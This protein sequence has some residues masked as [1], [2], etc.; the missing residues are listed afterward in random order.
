MAP[1]ISRPASPCFE[2]NLLFYHVKEASNAIKSV[3]GLH[4]QSDLKTPFL[5]TFWRNYN[6][7][8]KNV[9]SGTY[10]FGKK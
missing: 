1:L 4:Y 7:E 6:V 2:Y 5:W 8:E 3:I 9:G 10:F